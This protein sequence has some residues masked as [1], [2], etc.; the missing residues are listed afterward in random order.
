MVNLQIIRELISYSKNN[1]TLVL[2]NNI[3]S[4]VPLSRTRLD[5]LRKLLDI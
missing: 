2:G 5:E 3:Q 1:Y 4:K